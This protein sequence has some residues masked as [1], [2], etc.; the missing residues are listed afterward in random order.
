MSLTLQPGLL[1]TYKKPF[2]ALVVTLLVAARTLYDKRKRALEGRA[3]MV[4]HLIPWV[5]S[6][7]E[8]GKD[9]DAFFDRAR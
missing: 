4:P 7:L 1:L 8:L 3:P 6:G 2:A 9:P 5:G